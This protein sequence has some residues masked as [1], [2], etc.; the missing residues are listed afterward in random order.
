[1]A[2]NQQLRQI[3]DY[4]TNR[5]AKRQHWLERIPAD[6]RDNPQI[7]QVS[8]ILE[9]EIVLLDRQRSEAAR[10]M[11]QLRGEA[12]LP[13]TENYEPDPLRPELATS[14][15]QDSGERERL[16]DSFS[17]REQQLSNITTILDTLNTPQ[18][19]RARTQVQ[20]AV[21][22]LGEEL[23]QLRQTL[24]FSRRGSDSIE[25]GMPPPSGKPAASSAGDV[26]F[27]PSF[28]PISEPVSTSNSSSTQPSLPDPRDVAA[29][30]LAEAG[31]RELQQQRQRETPRSELFNQRGMMPHPSGGL[32]S[33]SRGVDLNP[34]F[35]PISEPRLA[36]PR[37]TN[38]F[39]PS[40]PASGGRRAPDETQAQPIESSRPLEP[41][42]ARAKSNQPDMP[43]RPGMPERL[44]QQF[45]DSVSDTTSE[46]DLTTE[47]DFSNLSS[48]SSVTSDSDFSD[49][50]SES[51]ITT[52]TY[53]RIDEIEQMDDFF[54]AGIA[55]QP[56]L[57]ERD[58]LQSR[59]PLQAQEDQA[60]HAVIQNNVSESAEPTTP[61][62]PIGLRESAELVEPVEPVKSRVND[63][64][65][66]SEQMIP[67]LSGM[68]PPMAPP[69]PQAQEEAGPVGRPPRAPTGGVGQLQMN[70]YLPAQSQVQFT[71]K[72]YMQ[73]I[74]ASIQAFRK[75]DEFAENPEDYLQTRINETGEKIDIDTL[76]QEVKTDLEYA[77][78]RMSSAKTILENIGGGENIRRAENLDKRIDVAEGRLAK[79]DNSPSPESPDSS[80]TP[81]PKG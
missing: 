55:D 9:H 26:G 5:I 79:L 14:S 27:N 2:Q 12:R 28:V 69:P 29:A 66:A 57:R 17:Q 20:R 65:Q 24:P 41:P 18:E 47:S 76:R 72:E 61:T 37:R 62:R 1:M 42:R 7:Q 53:E 56:E 77:L 60:T 22:F 39:E 48:V 44:E 64:S 67:A 36:Q 10:A 46:S 32:P 6:I 4:C 58:D 68:L 40:G 70:M 74:D 54:N 8:S 21:R 3:I 25:T 13:L 35:V 49:L 15:L 59:V 23:N 19:R 73:V 50:S 33:N 81:R 75:A 78:M 16:T 63:L 43:V 52:D 80:K 71:S 34:S 45:P 51:G 11:S 30:V 31:L 38:P